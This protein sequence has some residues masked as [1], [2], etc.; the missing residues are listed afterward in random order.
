MTTFEVLQSL[1]TDVGSRRA[2]TE[3]EKRA[4]DWLRAQ[5][6]A[7]G[8][9]VELDEFT[10]I[11]NEYYRPFLTLGIL[12][13]ILA[14]IGLSIAGYGLVSLILFIIL[15]AFLTFFLKHIDVRLARTP[16]KNVLAGL[17]R[18]FADYI[19]DPEKGT[20]VLVCG[21][22][23]TPRSFP[24][25]YGK[26]RGPMRFLGPLA[27][28]GLILGFALMIIEGIWN[29]LGSL[30]GAVEAIFNI[31]DWAALIFAV[32]FLLMMYVLT[33]YRM[34]GSRTDSPGTDDNGSGTA[35]VLSLAQRF[36]ENPVQNVDLFFGWWGAEEMG[37]FGSRQFVR[38][39]HE[40]L[41]KDKLHIINADCVGVGEYLTIHTGQGTLNRKNAEQS[42]ITRLEQ[43]AQN[44]GVKTVRSWES[45]ISGG[46]S[47]QAGWIDRGFKNTSLILRA[48]KQKLSLPSRAVGA[49]LRIPNVAQ[50]E[51]DH[52]HTPN[53]TLETINQEVLESSTAVAEAYIRSIDAELQQPG[54]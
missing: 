20:A 32:P 17:N 35:L 31:L 49:I 26:A 7:L 24:P 10:F 6:V 38:Q 3:G 19:A 54:G 27:I 40:K 16:S 37:L 36:K 52:I 18:S 13:W 41:D 53:D 22:Y 42:T 47:D 34:L 12:T 45:I 43:A 23:D 25:L 48:N 9:P 50:Y 15:F 8:L 14:S 46:S 5:C 44:T 2:G 11:G 28:L 51:L 30:P 21:H 39:H 33:I 4:Q 1:Q 29:A